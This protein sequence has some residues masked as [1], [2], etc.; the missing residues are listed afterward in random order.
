MCKVYCFIVVFVLISFVGMA[1]PEGFTKVTDTAYIMQN[2]NRVAL[3]TST[4]NTD[5]VQEKSL[6]FLDEKIISKGKLMYKKS[7]KFRLEYTSPFNYLLIMNGGKLLIKSDNNEI[8]INLESSKMFL[9]INTLIVNSI[10]GEI[11]NMPDMSTSFYENEDSFF[12]RM[13]PNQHE[14]KK[15]IKTIELYLSKQ[16]F[17]VTEFKVFELSD[18]YTL[19]KFVNKKINEEISNALFNTQ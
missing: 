1:Q 5:F 2:V 10:Q 11:M 9:E 8:K 16:D 17:T 18:D 14:L 12:V 7:D 15:Y 19:I 13:K 6:A 3:Q 4:I